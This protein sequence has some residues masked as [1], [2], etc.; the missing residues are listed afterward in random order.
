[1]IMRFRDTLSPKIYRKIFIN[2]LSYL[3]INSHF[4]SPTFSLS[5]SAKHMLGQKRK[6]SHANTVSMS[7]PH[8]YSDHTKSQI[9]E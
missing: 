3:L 9:T 6:D 8:I 4:L 7:N 5:H 1:M 2:Y